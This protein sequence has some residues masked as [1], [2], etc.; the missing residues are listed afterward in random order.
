MAKTAGK[1][2]AKLTHFGKCNPAEHSFFKSGEFTT[3]NAKSE[4]ILHLAFTC[5]KCSCG[6]SSMINVDQNGRHI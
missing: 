4:M 5:S 1:P 2:Q 3:K 6:F